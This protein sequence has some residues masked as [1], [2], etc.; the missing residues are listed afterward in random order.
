MTQTITP[1]M[2]QAFKEAYGYSLPW[3]NDNI[4]AGL[5]AAFAAAPEANPL[6]R[7]VEALESQMR[8]LHKIARKEMD[9]LMATNYVISTPPAPD[10]ED[11]AEDNTKP[12]VAD[13]LVRHCAGVYIRVLTDLDPA[14]GEIRHTKEAMRAALEAAAAVWGGEESH[15]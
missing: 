11:A 8:D 5:A 9:K 10:A 7:R 3:T 14:P 1:D 4:R 2:I 13:D 6:A 12:V 15:A